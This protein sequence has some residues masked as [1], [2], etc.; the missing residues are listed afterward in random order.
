[1]PFL[2]SHRTQR[3]H[4]MSGWVDL[5]RHSGEEKVEILLGVYAHESEST[6]AGSMTNYSPPKSASNRIPENHPLPV[7]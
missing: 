2:K 5:L 1:M 4:L 6:S 7:G 3:A